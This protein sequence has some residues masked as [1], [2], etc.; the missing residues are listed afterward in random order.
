M[1]RRILSVLCLAALASACFCSPLL[2]AQTGRD[3]E[4]TAAVTQALVRENP[5][6]YNRIDVKTFDGVVILGGLVDEYYKVQ[7][8]IEIARGIEGVKSVDNRI[9]IMSNRD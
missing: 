9:N 7:Q 4:I 2:A 6:E 1:A 5:L 3:L 8:V